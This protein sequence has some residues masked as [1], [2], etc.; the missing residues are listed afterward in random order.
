MTTGFTRHDL[1]PFAGRTTVNIEWLV[2][3][4][5]HRRDLG[6]IVLSHKTDTQGRNRVEF[7]Q[8]GREI[9]AFV[10]RK[11]AKALN[12]RL[13]K[14][15][16]TLAG[17]RSLSH[18]RLIEWR[19]RQLPWA[20]GTEKRDV[21]NGEPIALQHARIN[22]DPFARTIENPVGLLARARTTIQPSA[23]FA[24]E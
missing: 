21:D 12:D 8:D 7:A 1:L 2:K 5:R 23:K 17:R 9:A 15:V 16:S 19:Q 14:K 20:E 11:W 18:A 10:F 6:K 13:S 4:G 24:L 3:G 22:A